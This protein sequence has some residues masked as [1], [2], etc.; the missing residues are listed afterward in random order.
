MSNYTGRSVFDSLSPV[1]PSPAPTGAPATPSEPGVLLVLKSGAR[2]F[3]PR[4]KEATDDWEFRFI[5]ILDERRIPVAGETFM[6]KRF[7]RINEVAYA[8]VTTAAQADKAPDDVKAAV[9]EAVAAAA[10]AVDAAEEANA[11]ADEVLGI[12]SGDVSD[13]TEEQI[14]DAIDS[15]MAKNTNKIYGDGEDHGTVF[16]EILRLQAILTERRARPGP[17]PQATEFGTIVP[18]G[19]AN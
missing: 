10:K 2:V 19:T 18:P 5:E 11:A 9:A 8:E 7:L 16:S 15:L 13:W 4:P 1:P 6:N 17:A 14:R 3:V 12:G